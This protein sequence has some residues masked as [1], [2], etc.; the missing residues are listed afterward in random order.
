MKT[1]IY[2][3]TKI[4]YTDYLAEEILPGMFEVT[5]ACNEDIVAIIMVNKKQLNRL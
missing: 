1:L 4:N 3:G 2:N 5:L